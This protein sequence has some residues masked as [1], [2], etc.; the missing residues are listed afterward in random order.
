MGQ[1]LYNHPCGLLEIKCPACAETI[2]LLDL[3]T[4]AEYKP[5][6]FF[7]QYKDGTYHLKKSHD[8]YHQVQGQLYITGRP[9]CDFVVW[10]PTFTSIERIWFDGVLWSKKMYPR[11]KILHEL[12]SARAGKSSTSGA[13]DTRKC[14]FFTEFTIV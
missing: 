13:A 6:A 5:S 1:F 11:L 12:T 8:Y 4:K 7:L 14:P 10:T 2:S 9:W 3:C